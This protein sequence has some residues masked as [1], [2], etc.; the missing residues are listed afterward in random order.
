MS[1]R[2]H[3]GAPLDLGAL[4]VVRTTLERLR[5]E[6]LLHG[7]SRLAALLWFSEQEALRA[8]EAEQEDKADDI[9]Q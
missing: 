9:R 4:E 6:A 7:Q 3:G 5:K 8:Q 1:E 2:D